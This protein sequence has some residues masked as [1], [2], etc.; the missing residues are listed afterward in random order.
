MYYITLLHQLLEEYQ[1]FTVSTS[2]G[3]GVV[4]AV[5]FLFQRLDHVICWPAKEPDRAD[6]NAFDGLVDIGINEMFRRLRSE[7]FHI[8]AIV[9]RFLRATIVSFH[10]K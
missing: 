6:S 10:T 1:K 2:P 4:V 8:L 9:L 3:V 5:A 7:I